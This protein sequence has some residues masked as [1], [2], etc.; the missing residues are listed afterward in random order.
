MY[1]NIKNYIYFNR[2]THNTNR[3]RFVPWG[4]SNLSNSTFL[5]MPVAS[6]ITVQAEINGETVVRPYT[7]VSLPNTVGHFD[8]VIKRYPQGIMSRHI[9]GLNVGEKLLVKGPF[10]KIPVT[11]NL[12]RELGLI[13]GGTGITPM[14]QIIQHVL[15]TPN[16]ITKLSLLF[17]NV[18]TND[19]LLK[20]ELDELAQQHRDRFRVTYKV[21]RISDD[22][23]WKGEV[24]RINVEMIKRHMPRPSSIED[25]SVLVMVCGPPG[26]MQLVSGELT[27]DYT[28]GEVTGL[29]KE[30]GYSEKNVFKF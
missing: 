12:K 28:Q 22:E 23:D 14:Y 3:F 30:A 4:D 19:I 10:S 29:L 17:A 16:D 9:H 6:C 26:M 7:P 1:S 20:R 24:G 15:Q 21:D 13:A 27:K 18:S 2:V 11:L 8:L 5:N 25:D